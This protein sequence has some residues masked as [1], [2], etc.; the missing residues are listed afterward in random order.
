MTINEIGLEGPA[1]R[2]ERVPPPEGVKWAITQSNGEPAL[3]RKL[4]IEAKSGDWKKLASMMALIEGGLQNSLKGAPN[5]AGYR[6]NLFVEIDSEDG[7]TAEAVISQALV[8]AGFN[9]ITIRRMTPEQT[10]RRLIID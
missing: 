1:P 2:P 5:M 4:V 10:G 6:V 7:N 3:D 9:E 8:K